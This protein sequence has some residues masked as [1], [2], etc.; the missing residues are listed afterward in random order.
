[1]SGETSRT[2]SHLIGQKGHVLL[3]GD[4]RIPVEVTDTRWIFGRT[5][6][7]VTPTNGEGGRWVHALSFTPARL[8]EPSSPAPEIL[9]RLLAPVEPEP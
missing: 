9:G 3:G 5:E 2:M 1:M 4:M 7:F 8:A 6:L